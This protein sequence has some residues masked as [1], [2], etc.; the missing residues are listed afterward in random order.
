MSDFTESSRID[1]DAVAA[2][3]RKDP[4]Q[5]KGAEIAQGASFGDGAMQA[6]TETESV[7]I[8]ESPPC[9]DEAGFTSPIRVGVGLDT[10][11]AR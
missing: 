4:M 1:Q 7:A 3:P 10:F 5:Q 11:L 8:P 2:E 6:Y 9:G